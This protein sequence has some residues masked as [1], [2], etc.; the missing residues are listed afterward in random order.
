MKKS[1]IILAMA[2]LLSACSQEADDLAGAPAGDSRQAVF[3]VDMSGWSSGTRAAAISGGVSATAD[4]TAANFHL[5]C[6]N[7]HGYLL[8]IGTNT[9][10]SNGTVTATIPGNTARLH[11]VA[12]A[13][14]TIDADTWTQGASET[15]VLSSIASKGDIA[16]WGYIP[17][18]DPTAT[19][20][21]ISLLRNVA[22]ITFNT[23]A[24]AVSGKTA[25]YIVANVVLNSGTVAPLNQ[26]N[27]DAPFSMTPDFPTI[28]PDATYSS[29]TDWLPVSSETFIYESPNSGVSPV[30]VIMRIQ[31]D[32]QSWTYYQI[33]LLDSNGLY[34]AVVRNHNYRININKLPAA[35]GYDTEAGAVDG[36]PVNKVNPGGQT[37]TAAADITVERLPQA[38][39][40][41]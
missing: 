33:R 22:K 27:L 30:K 5:L 40:V 25:E 35:A 16:C 11:F 26:Q 38:V 7:T 29:T 41:R 2:A 28:A 31:N 14:A 39:P 24:T 6:F 23:A 4:I 17:D 12:S 18:Y 36:E 20:Q 8:G 15:N 19:G 10:V 32:D 13:T 3:N 34:Y 9:A 21:S 37:R 1:T